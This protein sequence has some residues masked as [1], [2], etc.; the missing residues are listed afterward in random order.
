M[1]MDDYLY[2]VAV[3]NLKNIPDLAKKQALF[4]LE[5]G[6]VIYLP[7]YS[8][9]INAEEQILLSE[10]IL[11][12]KHKNISYDIYAKVEKNTKEK[13]KRTDSLENSCNHGSDSKTD[14]K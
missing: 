5:S 4:S 11:N 6:K 14:L 8:F 13:R 9:A 10:S 7:D 1:V 2:T 12:P 3:K